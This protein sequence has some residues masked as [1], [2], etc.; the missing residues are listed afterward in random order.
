MEGTTA[1]GDNGEDEETRE[2]KRTSRAVELKKGLV[3]GFLAWC[4]EGRKVVPNV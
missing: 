2:E 3:F 1:G 4:V